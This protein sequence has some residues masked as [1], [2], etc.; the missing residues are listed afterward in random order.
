MD[1]ST[2]LYNERAFTATR[3]RLIARFINTPEREQ[4]FREIHG[5]TWRASMAMRVAMNDDLMP[6]QMFLL[7]HDASRSDEPFHDI[8]IISVTLV[9]LMIAKCRQLSR[10]RFKLR[11]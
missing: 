8:S 11:L 6:L 4:T 10:R 3:H 2:R 7:R 1:D 5:I 9:Q